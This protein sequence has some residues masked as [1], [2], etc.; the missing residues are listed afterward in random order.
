VLKH[1]DFDL[2]L[3]IRLVKCYAWTVLLYDMEGALWTRCNERYQFLQLII[4]GKRGI[5][6]KKM[7]RLRNVR[8]WTGLR[9]M[10][11]IRNKEE[12]TNMIAN[13]H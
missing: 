11:T 7:S 13:I 10:H 6:R 5:G 12:W 8:Q 4:E 2:G 3:R 9:T 1:T